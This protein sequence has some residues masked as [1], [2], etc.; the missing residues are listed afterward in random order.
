MDATLRFVTTDEEKE[1]VYRL[2]YELYVE[3]Q[4]LFMDEADHERRWLTDSHDAESP[5]IVAEIEGRLV[6]TIRLTWG[7]ATHF[8]QASR[9]SYDVPRFEGVVDERDIILVSRLLVRPELRG[10]PLGCQ[11]FSKVFEFAAEHNAELILGTCEIHLVSHYRKLGFRPFGE[12]YNHPTN[13]I[14]V[15]IVAVT[16]DFDYLQRVG[17]TTLDILRRRSRPTRHLEQIVARAT[18]GLC[19]ESQE[20]HDPEQ[21]RREVCRS[22]AGAEGEPCGLIRDLSPD[23]TQTLLVK[24]HILT[25]ATGDALFLKGHVSR[26]L[27]VLLSGSLEVR[28]NG[29]VTRIEERGAAVGEVATLSS[30]PR[31][32]DVVAGSQGARVLALS[33]GNLRRIMAGHSSL[34][35][36]LL[37]FLALGLC[38]QLVERDQLVARDQLL[39]RDQDPREPIVERRPK[40]RRWSH[41]AQGGLGSVSHRLPSRRPSH[42]G[43]TSRRYLRSGSASVG[44]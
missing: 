43:T 41:R 25:C 42:S 16:G 22:I 24:S 38:D 31:I 29:A 40:I 13:G 6:G 15:P 19:I 4:G 37:R 39:A 35:A 2:R 21:Y 1:A 20:L 26:T 11:L 8:G 12:L 5:I 10:G 9:E 28:A 27:F 30:H 23:E 14:L 7:G 36:K 44:R 33:Y 18:E 34:A 3:D 32:H 17:A